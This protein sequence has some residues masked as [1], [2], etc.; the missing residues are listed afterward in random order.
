MIVEGQQCNSQQDDMNLY[1]VNN[2]NMSGLLDIFTKRQFHEN[3]LWTVDLTNLSEPLDDVL[4]K[5]DKL[6]AEFDDEI[7]LFRVNNMSYIS[8][9]EVYKIS[10]NTPLRT[11]NEGYWSEESGV[12]LENENHRNKRLR[13]LQGLH[14]KLASKVSKPYI[15]EMIPNNETGYTMRGVFAE[16]FHNL[17]VSGRPKCLIVCTKKSISL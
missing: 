9:W 2:Q 12:I 4:K 13:D 7:L 16:V 6:E 5:L 8:F 10:Q 1:Y 14:L 3:S 17:Q 11:A 15:L